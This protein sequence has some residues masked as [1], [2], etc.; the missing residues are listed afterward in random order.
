M[1]FYAAV[2]KLN[3][4]VSSSLFTSFSILYTFINFKSLVCT[5]NSYST[6]TCN[7]FGK[8]CV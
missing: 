7:M 4:R 2:I 8:E 6:F 3:A 5:D 1:Q